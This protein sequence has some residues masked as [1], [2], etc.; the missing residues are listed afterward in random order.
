[1]SLFEQMSEAQASRCHRSKI[2]RLPIQRTHTTSPTLKHAVPRQGI[3]MFNLPDSLLSRF[4]ML[5]VVLDQMNDQ[6]DR[7]MA[8]HVIRQHRYRPAGEDGKGAPVQESIHDRQLEFEPDADE[9]LKHDVRLHGSL[10]SGPGGAPLE[11]LKSDFLRKYIIACRRRYGKEGVKIT[12]TDAAAERVVD[13][14]QELRANGQ[15][16]ALPVTARTL[17]TIIRLAT[18]MCKVRYKFQIE[19]SDVDVATDI[20]DHVMRKDV[21]CDDEPEDNGEE[22]EEDYLEEPDRPAQP[23]RK[24]ASRKRTETGDG[25]APADDAEASAEESSR[26]SKR[27]ATEAS[28]RQAA[29][30]MMQA[31]GL[32]SSSSAPQEQ[33]IDAGGVLSDKQRAVVV[34]VIGECLTE[35][36]DDFIPL[37]ELQARLRDRKLVIADSV[38]AEFLT[39]CQENYDSKEWRTKL[40]P[41][42]YDKDE[43]NFVGV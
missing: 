28:V 5:F 35:L 32:P 31:M 1:M 12:I 19:E 7:E 33:R 34:E 42:V 10:T 4:D 23:P 13:Y 3:G 30:P 27:R 8:M 37:D 20:L 17:E 11:V 18:A 25:E 39:F 24:K 36:Q 38:L 40:P 41:I 9:G 21:G 2:W 26:R 29:G 15:D 16:R 22:A 6:R 43:K 14:Y